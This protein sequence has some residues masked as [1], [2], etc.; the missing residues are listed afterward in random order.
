MSAP[1]TKLDFE[2]VVVGTGFAGAV[3]ACRLVQAGMR[4]CVLERGRRYAAG[5]LPVYPDERSSGAATDESANSG[6]A[7]NG[8]GSEYVQPDLS[9]LF[10]GLGQ[11]LWDVRN[12]GDVVVGQAA[13]YGGGSLIYANAHLRAPAAVFEQGWPEP[14][15]RAALDPYYDLAAYMLDVKPLPLHTTLPKTVQLQRAAN[16]LGRKDHF[17][18]PP[19]AIHFE[20]DGPRE[21]WRRPQ[22]PCDLRGDCCFGCPRQAKNTLDLNY[23][24]IVEDA[25]CD[26]GQGGQESL[27]DIRTLAEVA[28]IEP[29][30]GDP[31][32]GYRVAYRDHLF[33]GKPKFVTARYVFLCAGA[34]NTTELLLQADPLPV[35]GAGAL[36]TRYH[37][38]ADTVAAVFDSEPLQEADRGPTITGTVLHR[39]ADHWFLIQDGGMPAAL[40]PLLGVF[41]SPLWARRNRHREGLEP[42]DRRQEDAGLAELPFGNVLDVLSGLTRSS[43]RPGLSQTGAIGERLRA[44]TRGPAAY[45]DWRLL[46]DQLEEAIAQARSELLDALVARGEPMIDKFLVR[47]AGQVE[48]EYKLGKILERFPLPGVDPAGVRELELPQRILRLGIQLAFGSQGALVRAIAEDVLNGIAPDPGV[49]LSRLS[50]VLKYLLDY[51]LSDGHTALLLSMGRDSKPGRLHLDPGPTT[52]AARLRASLPCPENLPE[53]SVQE[54][55]LRDI[56]HFWDGELRTNPAWTFM[57]R[58]ITVHSQGGCPMTADEKGSVTGPDGQVRGCPGLYVMDASAFPTSVGVNPSATIAAVAEY[59]VER[60]IHTELGKRDWVPDQG[61]AAVSWAESRAP[62]ELD[63]IGEIERQATGDS[64]PPVRQPIG[65]EF[66]ETMTGFLAAPDPSNPGDCRAHIQAQPGVPFE[67][68][69]FADFEE[70]GTAASETLDLVL[71]TVRVEDLSLFLDAHRRGEAT[72]MFVEGTIEL[73]TAGGAK[74]S[75]TVAYDR[76]SHLELQKVVQAGEEIRELYYELH[77]DIAGAPHVLRGRKLIRDDPSFD[78]WED[79][80]TLFFELIRADSGKVTRRGVLRL[81]AVEFFGKQLGSFEAI[82]TEDPA[83]RAWALA[84]FGEYFFSQLVEVYVPRIGPAIEFLQRL[85]QRT[86]V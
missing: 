37:A 3:T 39:D 60:F 23:L 5:D 56:A 36:G 48:E 2:A 77:F 68:Q 42:K 76:R 19:L 43:L 40:E 63:P 64:P 85:T 58:R 13:G 74:Q 70:R 73:G 55:L 4:I 14:Y 46:P 35:E 26:D 41:R 31:S 61:K 33:N 6:A 79:T 16:E 25:V 78:I 24:A 17:F 29:V 83:R 62:G 84:A 8:I 86:H 34:V 15:S 47:A 30:D 12:L 10:W 54:R 82:G 49:L 80:A 38:N 53:R 71:E 27:A 67:P 52:R 22:K 44:A 32:Q 11:G 18:R 66:Q 7:P 75:H 51:R 28:G 72:R 59:K 1:D 69:R 21:A 20:G 45:T 65:I 81:P 50:D 57:D 9:R